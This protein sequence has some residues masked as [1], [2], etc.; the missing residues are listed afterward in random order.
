[1]VKPKITAISDEFSGR[2]S[3]VVKYL[4][5]RGLR[6]VELRGVALP[7]FKWKRPGDYTDEE[8]LFVKNCVKKYEISV[9]ALGSPLFNRNPPKTDA[10]ISD[11]LNKITR[12]CEVA[13]KLECKHIRIF[14]FHPNPPNV[15]RDYDNKDSEF[16]KQFLHISGFL[17]KAADIAEKYNV[18]LAMENEPGLFGDTADNGIRLIKAINSNH[19]GLL[20][21][22]GNMWKYLDDEPPEMMKKMYPYTIYAHIKDVGVGKDNKRIHVVNGL[23]IMPYVQVF[24]D[25]LKSNYDSFFS[26]ETHMHGLRRWRNSVNCLNGLI[27]LLGKAGWDVSQVN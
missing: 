6:Y 20:F 25:M 24:K 19:A 16:M 13:N 5:K 21:D 18:Y 2:L 12:N 8:I 17:R 11:A 3:K 1:M 27:D 22:P 26:V 4:Q 14:S 23:G 10:E 7:G 9:S 15:T